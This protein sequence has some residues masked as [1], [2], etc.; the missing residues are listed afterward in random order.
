MRGNRLLIPFLT[1]ISIVLA[2]CGA[3]PSTGGQTTYKDMKTMVID[4]LKTDEGKKAIQSSQSG[5][6][7]GGEQSTGQ[8]RL[9]SV[10]DQQQVQTAVKEVLVSPEYDKVIK[11][12]MTDTKFAGE[13]AKAVNKENKDIHKELI[14]DA[15]YQASF[16]KMLKD[17][18]AEKIF[19][20]T[21]QG[22][23]YRKEVMTIMQE[24]MQSPLFRLEMYELMKSAVKEELAPKPSSEKNKEEKSGQQGEKQQSEDKSKEE[25]KSKEEEKKKSNEE[26]SSNA[27]EEKQEE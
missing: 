20:E 13:F 23:Q 6:S 4:I 12:L 2:G 5:S 21:L 27:D 1:A 15:E 22:S 16:V 11:K 24:A 7:S 17:P 18:E 25:G 26:P 19:L 14:K 8:S 3:E 9:L 10:Q